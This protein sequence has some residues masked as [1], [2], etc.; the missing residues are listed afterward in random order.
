M[1][2][3]NNQIMIA[4]NDYP[5]HSYY[6]GVYLAG[7]PYEANFSS[8][9]GIGAKRS[10]QQE[11]NSGYQ[12]TQYNLPGNIELSPITLKKGIVSAL[13]FFSTWVQSQTSTFTMYQ[14]VPMVIM[15]KDRSGIPKISWMFTNCIP[16]SWKLGTLDAEATGESAILFEEVEIAYQTITQ[17]PLS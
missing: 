15:L 9:D 3:F 4:A 2:F 5:L 13:S 17:I 11:Y 8:V 6:F 14:P 1:I 16:V 10:V 12:S 7:N